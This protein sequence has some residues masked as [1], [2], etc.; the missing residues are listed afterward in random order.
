MTAKKQ[1]QLPLSI[2]PKVP[3]D[4]VT[5][6]LFPAKKQGGPRTVILNNYQYD[7]GGF[8]PLDEDD[9]TIPALDIRHGRACFNILSF[10]HTLGD[11]LTSRFSLNEFCRRYANSNGGRYSRDARKLLSD[12]TKCW[13][14]ITYPD[15]KEL[16]YRI[17]ERV[18]VE[19]NF[20]RRKDSKL[21]KSKQMELWLDEVQ[22]SKEF[23]QFLT[24]VAALAR[25]RID[26]LNSITS[27]LAQAI[28]TYIPS[29]A[30]HATKE[31]PFKITATNLL[32]QVGENVPSYKSKRKEK[33]H[34]PN[35][36]RKTVI[37]Q[38]DGLELINGKFRVSIEETG[39][40]T[41]YNLLFWAED[42]TETTTPLPK[43]GGQS[44]LLDAYL[45]SGRGD[46]KQFDRLMKSKKP[47]HSYHEDLLEQSG[48]NYRD[49][50]DFLMMV[51]TI[52]GPRHFQTILA[53]LKGDILQP[54]SSGIKDP[55]GVLIHRL[56]NAIKHP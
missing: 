36:D 11:N 41:D 48:I 14:R 10:N 7:I 33:F 5:A 44:K 38:L 19:R 27:P 17:L 26:V 20:P 15:G 42:V 46:K 13:F 56:L 49:S 25:I 37:Q 3:K 50:T 32:Q 6:P 8:N 4:F 28:Y 43:P 29:R 2:A 53:E 22:F 30:I 55:R 40:K 35:K 1:P 39:D 47:L 54:G 16:S 18:V 21:A 9:T 34:K 31:T 12:L 45:A 23:H 51:L 52:I 24:K